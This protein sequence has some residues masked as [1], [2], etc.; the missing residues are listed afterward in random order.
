MARAEVLDFKAWKKWLSLDEAS[1]RLY[2]SKAWCTRC[3]VTS[4][5]DGYDVK[6]TKYAIVVVGHCAQCG[7]P[8]RRTIETL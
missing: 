1:R 2:L 8:I 3:R 7:A 6:S 5:A 4:F